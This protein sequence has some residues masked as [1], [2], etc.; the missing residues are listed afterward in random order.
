LRHL[1]E[2]LAVFATQYKRYFR[3]RP[4]INRPNKERN[5]G[6]VE[7]RFFWDATVFGPVVLPPQAKKLAEIL[8][9]GKA[10]A[11]TKERA[12]EFNPGSLYC[13]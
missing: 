7:R 2:R 3:A 8:K 12:R 4:Y 1:P 9:L 6:W 5:F 13:K 10:L 11:S